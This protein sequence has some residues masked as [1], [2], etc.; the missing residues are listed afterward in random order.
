[1]S[2]N[3]RA[4]KSTTFKDEQDGFVQSLMRRAAEHKFLFSPLSFKT[5]RDDLD[6]H[7]EVLQPSW[8]S[9]PSHETSFAL[10]EP[11]SSTNLVNSVGSVRT[12]TTLNIQ[13]SM[14]GV[15]NV[16][17]PNIHRTENYF[18]PGLKKGEKSCQLL[19]GSWV[20]LEEFEPS[21]NRRTIQLSR[22]ETAVA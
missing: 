9:S 21:N 19:T 4:N 12:C 2:S 13:W 11:L 14:S 6:L 10:V 1:M 20:W 7:L 15:V 5:F 16:L 3:C 17:T 18:S 22:P 8:K